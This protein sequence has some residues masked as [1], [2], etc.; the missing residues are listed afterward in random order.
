MSRIRNLVTTASSA[1]LLLSSAVGAA[2]QD[3]TYRSRT[4]ITFGGAL[5]GV[6]SVAA[7]LGGGSLD[8]EET[9]YIKGRRVRT[10][11][12]KTSSIL[13]MERGRVLSLDHSE[14]TYTEISFDSLKAA[15]QAM[16]QS[17]SQAGATPSAQ[18]AQPSEQQ[19]NIEYKTEVSLDRTGERQR[20]N[21][22]DAEQVFLTVTV[23]ARDKTAPPT[24][25]GARFVVLTE[26]W[27]TRSLPG[28]EQLAA[29]YE[30]QA[31]E[32]ADAGAKDMADALGAAMSGQPGQRTAFERAAEEMKKVEGTPVRTTIYMVGGTTEH[33]FD[34]AAL[35]ADQQP[36][37]GGRSLG[38]AARSALGGLLG[39]GRA[40]E[41]APEKE[42]TQA[43]LFKV[44]DELLE[45]RTGPVAETLFDTPAGYRRLGG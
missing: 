17:M 21:G 42:P 20:I 40:P 14:K 18:P 1:L 43:M 9:Q 15:F 25:P 38:N 32:L 10:D 37:S 27:N 31:A 33:A 39:G 44:V 3:F 23:D 24:D 4:A 16:A 7:R 11:V 36:K 34:R 13:D 22:F 6:A 45:V 30:E 2:S 29:I 28:Q 5:Q 19:S 41:P 26:L 8:W 12:E 35:L